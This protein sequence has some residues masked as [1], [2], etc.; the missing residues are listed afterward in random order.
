ME[1][2]A[3]RGGGKRHG[4]RDVVRGVD[5]AAKFVKGVR[6][7]R[8]KDDKFKTEK[9]ALVDNSNEHELNLPNNKTLMQKNWLHILSEGESGLF[10]EGAGST[11]WRVA[12]GA[13]RSPVKREQPSKEVVNE[14]ERMLQPQER[15]KQKLLQIFFTPLSRISNAHKSSQRT[16]TS[17]LGE[18]NST[19]QQQ[20]LSV[21]IP[22]DS[23]PQRVSCLV[24]LVT[25]LRC[26]QGI[27]SINNQ[28]KIKGDNMNNST[29][30]NHASTPL[31]ILASK[32]VSCRH[33]NTDPH[34]KV[35]FTLAEVLITLGIIGV[36]AAITLPTLIQNYQKTV[37]VNQL[38]KAYSVLNNGVKQMIVEQGCS[39]V[40][41]TNFSDNEG[42]VEVGLSLEDDFIKQFVKTFKLSNVQELTENNNIYSYSIKYLS[43]NET[44]NYSDLIVGV[45]GTTPDG[46]IVILGGIYYAGD[47]IFIDTNGL[48]SPNQWGRDIFA[49]KVS[50]KGAV[51][52]YYS[53]AALEVL[54][55][56]KTEKE[57]IETVEAGCNTSS[58]KTGVTCA[59]KII[60]DGWKMNY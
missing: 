30:T 45:G 36:V 49:F 56:E 4:V 23:V 21:V 43:G 3:S 18:V 44:M 25:R 20:P 38:K 13:F 58:E 41:C 17:S 48:K 54:N 15:G 55:L 16:A 6:T 26:K 33:S 14:L 8:R 57:R 37:Y 47:F 24:R 59:E 2:H 5:L 27:Q 60:M 29:K 7:I 35:A 50:L 46:M 39:D 42:N 9:V 22:S 32:S 10:A 11:R 40:T 51:V 28:I 52:P 53:K 31:G 34:K 12:G 1:R 19:I